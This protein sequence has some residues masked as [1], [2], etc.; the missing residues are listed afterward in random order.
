MVTMMVAM[1]VAGCRVGS[2]RRRAN[3]RWRVGRGAVVP[4]RQGRMMMMKKVWVEWHPVGVVGAI[5]PCA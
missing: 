4:G 1:A 3:R 5:V 2:E